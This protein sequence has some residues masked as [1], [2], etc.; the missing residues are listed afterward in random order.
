MNRRLLRFLGILSV[1]LAIL[2]LG[3]GGGVLLDRAVLSIIAPPSGIPT[4]A[5]LD[6]RL[7]GE[8]WTTIHQDYVDQKALPR[9]VSSGIKVSNQI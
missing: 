4:D 1:A 9:D 6:F 3:L 7:M 5:V 2:M 8:A